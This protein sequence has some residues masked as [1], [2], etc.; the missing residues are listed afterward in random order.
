MPVTTARNVAPAKS[1]DTHEAG[2]VGVLREDCPDSA[3]VRPIDD[4]KSE[5]G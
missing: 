5:G 1:Q 2:G 3:V 4:G